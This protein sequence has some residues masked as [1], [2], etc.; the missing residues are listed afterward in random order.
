MRACVRM[1]RTRALRDCPLWRAMMR[2]CYIGDLKGLCSLCQNEYRSRLR[3]VECFAYRRRN[4]IPGRC[5][6][7]MRAYRVGA[8]KNDSFVARQK[9]GSDALR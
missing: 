2:R 9:Q 3:R 1:R 8:G 7:C 6:G 4:R 5:P